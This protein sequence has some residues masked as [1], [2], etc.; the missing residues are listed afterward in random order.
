MKSKLLTSVLLVV[1]STFALASS[2]EELTPEEQEY[3]TWAAGIWDSLKRQTG[4]IKCK[5]QTKPTLAD[6]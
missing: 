2:N 6:I 3:V 1:L 5:R 4:E